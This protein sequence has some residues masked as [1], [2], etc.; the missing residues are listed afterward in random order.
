MDEWDGREVWNVIPQRGWA[1]KREKSKE[2]KI[3]KEGKAICN[4]GQIQSVSCL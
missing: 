2:G 3:G 4:I 1:E